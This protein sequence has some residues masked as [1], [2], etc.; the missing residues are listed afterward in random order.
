MNHVR[1]AFRLR[2]A[3]TKQKPEESFYGETQ[4]NF[5]RLN[6]TFAL[7]HG[8]MLPQMLPRN[9]V[10]DLLS[11]LHNKINHKYLLA[12]RLKVHTKQWDNGASVVGRFRRPTALYH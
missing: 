5:V 6:S 2:N 1:C 4:S 10:F 12:N 7:V 8:V 9:G 11:F 3:K